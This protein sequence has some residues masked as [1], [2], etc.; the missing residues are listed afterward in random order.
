MSPEDA[1]KKELALL[2][3]G[4][5]SS[6]TERVLNAGRPGWSRF[7]IVTER[8]LGVLAAKAPP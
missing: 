2:E 6:I 5:V 1:V 7:H 4:I 3:I 8:N